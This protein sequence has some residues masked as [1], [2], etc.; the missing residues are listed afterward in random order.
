[1]NIRICAIKRYIFRDIITCSMANIAIVARRADE[2]KY[3]RDAEI[4]RNKGLRC[5]VYQEIWNKLEAELEAE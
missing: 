1:M 5:G 3:W 2:C 4:S